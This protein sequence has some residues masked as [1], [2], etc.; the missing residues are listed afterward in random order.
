[1]ED[2][3][4]SIYVNELFDIYG[5]LLSNTQQKMIDLYYSKDLSLSE[6]S[7][8]ENISRNAVYDAL[9]KG[10]D[11]LNKYES[12]LKILEKINSLKKELDEEIF[13]KIKKILKEDN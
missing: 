5:C 4:K 7:I 12:K 3:K 1:M 6:I 2:L 8:Q 11:S 13:N 9:K 10:I